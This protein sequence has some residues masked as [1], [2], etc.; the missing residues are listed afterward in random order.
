MNVHSPS[1][2]FASTLK[3]DL[4]TQVTPAGNGISATPC[5]VEKTWIRET[6]WRPKWSL[7]HQLNYCCNHRPARTTVFWESLNIIRLSLSNWSWRFFLVKFRLLLL[8]DLC[9]FI[10]STLRGYS[11]NV[12]LNI[13]R[14]KISFKIKQGKPAWFALVHNARGE[15]CCCSDEHMLSAKWRS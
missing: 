1:D 11:S 2:L 10:L 15:D 7:L 12:T 5:A 14:W 9:H 8:G 3:I 13:S 6:E 4:L